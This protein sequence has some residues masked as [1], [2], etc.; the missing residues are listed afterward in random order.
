MDVLSSPEHGSGKPWIVT[1]ENFITDEE[2]DALISTNYK[3]ERS[4][5]TGST[6]EFGETG[7]ILSQ[8]RTSTNS[9]CRGD[10]LSHPRVK[11]LIN[12]IEKVTRVPQQNYESFQVLKYEEGKYRS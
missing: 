9:W 11:E 10:C 1:F 4:T 3:F 7:R 8:T 5:D 12:K 2:A 6:N